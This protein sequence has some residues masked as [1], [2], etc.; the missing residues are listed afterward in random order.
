M[1]LKNEISKVLTLAQRD[2]LKFVRDPGRVIA[3]FIFPVIFIGIMGVTFNSGIGEQTLGF[4]YV[5]YIFAGII[6]QTAFQSGFAGI[7]SLV[8]DREKDFS[9]SIFVAPVSRYSIVLGKILGETIVGTAQIV[10][11]LVLGI[12]LGV[13][14]TWFNILSIIPVTVVGA[15]VGAS[16]GVLAASQVN[17]PE[18]A[19][20]VFPFLIFPLIFLSGAFTPVNNLPLVLNILKFLNPIY[21]GVDLTRHIL[22]SGRPEIALVTANN[23]TLDIIVFTALGLISFVVG[24]FLFTRKEGNR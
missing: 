20:R 15:F 9:M 11:I 13:N 2:I 8:E 10:G 6:L 14:F 21:Y 3:V 18:T 4:N 22:F 5:D 12:L 19:Q 7:V 17:S 1:K 23:M 16:M 24:G